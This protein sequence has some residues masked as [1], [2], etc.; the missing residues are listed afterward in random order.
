MLIPQ[1]ASNPMFKVRCR[2]GELPAP[3]E[4]LGPSRLS[5]ATWPKR[6]NSSVLSHM[7]GPW[8]AHHAASTAPTGDV[9]QLSE[10]ST[11]LWPKL[12]ETSGKLAGVRLGHC[13]SF[14]NCRVVVVSNAGAQVAMDLAS[15]IR[16]RGRHCRPPPP[17]IPSVWTCGCHQFQ[18][19]QNFDHLSITH[20]TLI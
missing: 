8:I 11:R 17:F 3:T 1:Q 15:K 6:S 7:S 19:P 5:R 10:I 12:V 16:R 20:T 4:D 18:S 14:G 13:G 9:C 2:R